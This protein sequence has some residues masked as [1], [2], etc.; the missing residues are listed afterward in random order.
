MM[1]LGP[2]RPVAQ[3]MF[4]TGIENSYPTSPGPDGK[5][6]RIDEMEKCRHYQH[7]REDFQLTREMGIQYLRYGPP[8]YKTHL[9][10]GK[11]DW[12]FTDETFHA[13][14][15]LRIEPIADL[16]H[17]GVPDWI[18]TFQNPDF[19]RLF[20]DYAKAFA[21][22][23]PGVKR[24][25]PVNEIYVAAT[26]SAQLGWWNERLSSDKAFVTALKHL[27]QANVLAM[28]AI[29]E[30]QPDAMFIQSESSEY[31]HADGPAA[32]ENAFFFNEKRFMAL[33]LTYGFPIRSVMYDY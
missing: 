11:Y 23:F 12:A 27:C 29:L 8:Y 3:F 32:V 28:R 2:S 31:F 5:P 33:D 24:Y 18:G 22:R 20:A 25:T 21:A 17:F 15:E 30:V 10:P 7:W 9:G 4:A 13:L 6:K 1:H 16:C 19:P 26:F 14:A